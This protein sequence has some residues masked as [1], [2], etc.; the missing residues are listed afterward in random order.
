M[1]LSVGLPLLDQHVCRVH[2]WSRLAELALAREPAGRDSCPVS[3][4]QSRHAPNHWIVGAARSA[5]FGGERAVLPRTGLMLEGAKA[6]ISSWSLGPTRYTV[7]R[8]GRTMRRERPA[9]R[10]PAHLSTGVVDL[11]VIVT[12]G[13]KIGER[14]HPP[15]ALF[16]APRRLRRQRMLPSRSPIVGGACVLRCGSSQSYRGASRGGLQEDGPGAQR[17]GRTWTHKARR[18]GRESV[19]LAPLE[20]GRAGARAPLGRGSSVATAH[21]KHHLTSRL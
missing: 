18:L 14:T 10:P 5:T 4:T 8:T 3:V 9:P 2:W 7:R 15:G 12:R 21:S 17:L 20:P 1:L 11:D 6:S 16:W 19:P 13:P